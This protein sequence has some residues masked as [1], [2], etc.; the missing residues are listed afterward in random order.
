ML[1]KG[2]KEKKVVQKVKHLS[3]WMNV[4]AVFILGSKHEYSR[5]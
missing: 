3:W 2:K 4:F 1:H 5:K